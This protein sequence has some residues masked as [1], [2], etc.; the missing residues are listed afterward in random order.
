MHVAAPGKDIVSTWLGDDYRKASGT[1]MAAPHVAGV[2]ALILAK[3]PDLSVTELR[4]KVLRSVD[5]I[6]TLEGKVSSGGRINA[7][8]AVAN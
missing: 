3:Y 4:A 6:D 2:A 1:S 7:S 5:K 8:K